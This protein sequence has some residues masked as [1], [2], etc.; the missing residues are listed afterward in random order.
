MIS[1]DLKD[2]AAPEGHAADAATGAAQAQ[3]LVCAGNSPCGRL[4]LTLAQDAEADGPRSG[5]AQVRALAQAEALIRAVEAWLSGPWDPV[6][7]G[8]DAA[9]SPSLYRAVVRD[10]GLARPGSHVSVPLAALRVPPPEALR[11]PALEWDTHDATVVLGEVPTEALAQLAVGALLWL[12]GS[13][14]AAWDV[15][16]TD[17][18]E[19][20]PP[21]G[22]QLDLAAQRLV[23]P[24]ARGRGGGGVAAPFDAAALQVVLSRPVRLPLD[25]W[26]GW[27]P[28][29]A[30]YYWPT[31]QPWAAELRHGPVV[32]ARGAL[33]PAGGGCGLRIEWLALP[34]VAV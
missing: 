26:L 18:A 12:P 11:A 2:T 33:L 27:G 23:V 34:E 20:L 31:P 28:A 30:A 15:R 24:A 9:S 10:P 8:V 21:C 17:G 16:L 22:A 6:P 14:A 29:G 32:L 3:P 19:R 1:H 5:A 4:W 7:V 25:R 13:F